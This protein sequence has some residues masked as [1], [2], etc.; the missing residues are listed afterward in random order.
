MQFGL[1]RFEG[2][3]GNNINRIPSEIGKIRDINGVIS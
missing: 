2:A 1:I 3:F